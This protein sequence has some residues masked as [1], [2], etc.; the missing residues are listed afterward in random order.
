[1]KFESAASRHLL[2]VES[3]LEDVLTRLNEGVSGI[4][5]LI[6]QN[7]ALCGLCTDGDVRRALL[8]GS[9]M[10]AGAQTFMNTAFTSGHVTMTR[11]EKLALLNDKIRHVPIL[12]D[13][14]QVH[15]VITWAE[16]WR[17]P[18]VEPSLAGNELKYVTECIRTNWISSQGT[19]VSRFESDFAN[20]HG[21]SH[22]VACSSGTTALHLG[23]LALDI[24]PGDEVLV[25]D[26]TF[27]AS[28]NAVIHAGA[29]PVFVDIE[30]KTWTIDV[31]QARS[32]ISPRTRAIMPVHLYGLPCNMNAIGELARAHDLKIVEDCAEALG[33]RYQNQLVGTFGH[34]SAYSFFAN[35]TI[36]TGEGGM[37]LTNDPDIA[38]KMRLYRDHGMRPGK[39]YWHDVVGFNYRITNL[40]SAIGCAQ[41]ERLDE[42]LVRR[43]EIAF[44]Y[45]EALA[46]I[47]WL[48]CQ[49]IPE[50]LYS[51]YWLFSM[52]IDEGMS[53]GRDDLCQRLREEGID[54][55]PLFYPLHEQPAFAEYRSGECK[56]SRSLAYR[57]FSLPTSNH[58]NM[59]DANRVVQAVRRIV[60][61]HQ[62]LSK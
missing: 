51:T 55:R 52:V 27:G 15:E 1:M 8:N 22:A 25:P 7:E 6:D 42:F 47:N 56:V 10:S 31:E 26:L 28:A 61:R 57:G 29:R 37:V 43:R 30:P 49:R 12:D 20:Y 34:V 32:L 35:K 41:L 19:F 18:L 9:A 16:I 21:M 62:W 23:L 48:H 13:Q 36:T 45:L 58:M 39:R 24:E 54:T 2:P 3:T 60:D 11:E 38:G 4:V 40:Q 50:D 53:F 5:C 33:A 59:E 14:K 44:T 46:D 17:M